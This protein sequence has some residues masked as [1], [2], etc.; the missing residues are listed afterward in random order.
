MALCSV[1]D[2]EG[3]VQI[4]FSDTL[5][6]S[7]TNYIIPYA[8]SVIKTYLGYD[9]EQ[10]DHTEVIFGNNLREISLKQIPV[11]SITLLEDSAVGSAFAVVKV[12]LAEPATDFDK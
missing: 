1:T 12:T 2:V 4:D 7:I 9:V 5:E 11:N 8:D 10:A 6:T 3:I